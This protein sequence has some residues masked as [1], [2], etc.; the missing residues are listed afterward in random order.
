MS[1]KEALTK[2]PVDSRRK[3]SVKD[4]IGML[5]AD[6]RAAAN[7]MLDDPGWPTTD[8]AA[9]F[10]AE[11]FQRGLSVVSRHRRGLCSCR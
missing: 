2:P 5:P 4:W 9:A 7:G 3:C 6:E 11:G 10:R 8:I 1:L